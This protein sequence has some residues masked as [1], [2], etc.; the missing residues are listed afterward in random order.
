MKDA[1]TS[2]INAAWSWLRQPSLREG[3]LE[4]LAGRTALPKSE[5]FHTYWA[6]AGVPEQE[7]VAAL[8]L[9][10]LEFEIDAGLLR[11]SDPLDLLFSPPATRHPLRWMEIQTAC[12][13]RQREFSWQL[14]KRLRRHGT[15]AYW[16]RVMTVDEFI[17]AWGG[18][19][20]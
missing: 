8:D 14:C 5:M 19:L 18:L 12:G 1:V 6:D 15:V 16:P 11:P 4:R 13:D 10:E 7:V 3:I 20:P 17:R 2:S 9:I